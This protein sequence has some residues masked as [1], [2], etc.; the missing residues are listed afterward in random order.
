[1]RHR[2]YRRMAV[3][4]VIAL[5]RGYRAL[6]L[7]AG[8]IPAQSCLPKIGRCSSRPGNYLYV[9]SKDKEVGDV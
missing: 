6:D 4:D 3:E 9:E 7:R 5:V 2:E 8:F 1:M